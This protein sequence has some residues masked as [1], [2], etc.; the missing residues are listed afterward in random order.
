MVHSLDPDLALKQA[1][2]FP[3][4]LTRKLNFQRVSVYTESRANGRRIRDLNPDPRVGPAPLHLLISSPV[5]TCV[6]LRRMRKGLQR[7]THVLC[8][9]LAC[10]LAGAGIPGTSGREAVTR[11]MWKGGRGKA[12]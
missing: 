4:W 7:G 8:K 2:Y 3:V 1:R 9:S 12:A 11:D 5:S 10:S 6:P